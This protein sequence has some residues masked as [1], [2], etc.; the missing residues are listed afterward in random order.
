MGFP[1]LNNYDYS[2]ILG[3][4]FYDKLAI[5]QN[6]WNLNTDLHLSIIESKDRLVHQTTAKRSA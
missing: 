4:Y 6:C 3:P 5:R 2:A 1:M